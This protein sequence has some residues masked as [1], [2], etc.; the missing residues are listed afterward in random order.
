MQFAW[1]AGY[2]KLGLKG[3]KMKKAYA[4]LGL[5]LIMALLPTFFSTVEGIW[6]ETF[7]QIR[8]LLGTA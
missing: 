4:L 3:G 6:Y 7:L 8:R 1:I 2:A 5:V